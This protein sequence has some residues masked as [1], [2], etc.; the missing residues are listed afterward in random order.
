MGEITEWP[1]AALKSFRLV[2]RGSTLQMKFRVNDGDETVRFR[3]GDTDRGRAWEEQL[4]ACLVGGAGDPSGRSA[5]ERLKPVAVLRKRLEIRH[6]VLGHLEVEGSAV[7][8]LARPE[9]KP[10]GALIGADAVF[11]VHPDPVLS[12]ARRWR[13][14]GLTG[15]AVRAVDADGSGGDP[16]DEV[17]ELHRLPR[18]IFTTYLMACFAVEFSIV[19]ISNIF[20][21]NNYL[22]L[23]ILFMTPYV[24]PLVLVASLRHA[25]VGPAPAGVNCPRCL[26][27]LTGSSSSI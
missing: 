19:T 17:S 25:P 6:Q 20:L 16:P 18:K 5:G 7:A 22:I 3:F 9:S 2:G 21:N 4:R 26:W 1:I 12:A 11:D 8:P 24:L 15:T 27:G 14:T 13:R 23:I 10:V